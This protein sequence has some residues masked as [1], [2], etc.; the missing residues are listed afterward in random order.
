[1]VFFNFFAYQKLNGVWDHL[2]A[3]CCRSYVT[4]A[5]NVPAATNAYTTVEELIR[6]C[7]IFGW[8]SGTGAGFLRVLRLPMPVFI[9]S[10]AP[11]SSSII[12]GWYNMPNIGRRTKWILSHTPHQ[13]TKKWRYLLCSEDLVVLEVPPAV[14]YQNWSSGSRSTTCSNVSELDQWF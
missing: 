5:L 12:R 1:V 7:M 9:S 2:A 11:R 4:D 3:V 13:E 14:T 10:I 8:Q 6:P